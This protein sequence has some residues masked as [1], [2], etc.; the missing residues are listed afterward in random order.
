MDMQVA[1]KKLGLKE[2]YSVMTRGLDWT[3]SYQKMEDIY[4]YIAYEG[5]KIHDWDKWEDPFRLTMDAYWKYQA[6]K[7]RKLYAIIDAFNQNNGHLNVTDA[8]YINTVKLFISGISPLEYVAH[9]GFAHAGRAFPGPGPRVACLMQSL[10][11]IRHAQ[12]QVHAISNYNKYYNG[13]HDFHHMHDRVWFL[14]VPKS[15]FDDAITAGPFEFMVS[16]GFS[17]EYVLTNLLFVPFV[18]GAAYNGDMGTMTFGFSAQSDEARH[19]TLGLEVIKF[20]LEQDPANVPI[21]QRWIDKWTW[22]GYRVLTL[23]AMMMDYML[24]KRT[25]SWKEAW[26]VYFEENGGALF[27]DLARYGIKMP[28]CAEQIA[29][30]KDHLSHQAWS[31]FYNYA[32]AANFHTW[33]PDEDEMAWLSAKYP[34][35]FDKHYRPRYEFWREQAA[36][37][38]RFY[39]KTLPMLCQICQIPMVFTEPGDP[40]KICY[41]EVD[42]KGDK[43]HFCSDH[44]KEIFEHEPEKYVQAWLPV[45]QIYQGNC[46]PEGTDPTVEGF[47]ALGAVLKYYNLEHGRDNLDFDI[48]ED[49]K[50]FAEWRGQATK[51]I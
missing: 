18:S 10:D 25:M 23:V 30:E 40:T 12:T 42:Y 49:K 3:P 46:F 6:E 28:K 9:R 21:V 37:G 22:R 29:L 24:P 33:M 1:K 27:K 8:R 11:E 2:R 19:M 48:S 36:K 47:D 7:E 15:F 32:A 20:I 16:I 31:T 35:S 17:F 45:H 13:M 14:S 43:Y 39:N 38:N 41:R 44:C 34:N 5:I 50:N 51:N 4:P 26:E